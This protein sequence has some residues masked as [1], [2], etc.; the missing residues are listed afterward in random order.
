MQSKYF[1]QILIISTLNFASHGKAQD[2]KIGCKNRI[3]IAPAQV[4]DTIFGE[5]LEEKSRA[6]IAE[7]FQLPCLAHRFVDANI[8]RENF[9]YIGMNSYF[10]IRPDNLPS[11][12]IERTILI[13][14]IHCCFL[15]SARIFNLEEKQP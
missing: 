9:D 5:A 11:E 14:L 6:L 10:T 15:M 2:N 4:K 7:H 1:L 8:A 12:K 3:I 13:C